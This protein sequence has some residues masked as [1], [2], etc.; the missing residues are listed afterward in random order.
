M[1]E[2]FDIPVTYK[3]KELLFPAKLL[4]LGYIY[5]FLVDV[6]GIEVFF[7]KDEEGNFRASV[8]PSKVIEGVKIDVGLLEAIAISLEEILK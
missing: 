2:S 5:K 3:N 4:H 6:S 1:D 7:E 8:D